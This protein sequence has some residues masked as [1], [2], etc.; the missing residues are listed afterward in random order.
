MLAIFAQAGEFRVF[1]GERSE[2]RRF[3]DGSIN[4]AV[5][6]TGGSVGER[7]GVVAQIITHL[8]H[9]SAWWGGHC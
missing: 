8:L 6:W 4:E 5:V 2:L 1:W 7:R 3:Q 9:R